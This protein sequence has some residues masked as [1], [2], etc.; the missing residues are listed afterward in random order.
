M[1]KKVLVLPGDN[2]GPE[3]V[4]EAV[5]VLERVSEQ[6]DLGIELDYAHLGGAALDAVGEPCPKETLDKARASDAILLGAVGGPQWDDVERHLRPEKGLLSIRSELDLFGNLRPAIMY[7][8]LAH[9]SSL[10]PEFVSGLDILIVRELVGGIY[11]GEPRG[12]R[13][14]ENGEREGFNT[15][16][17]NESE[18]RRIGKMAFEAAMVRGKRL[19]SVDKSNVLEATILWREI[20]SDMAADYPEVAL[21]HMYVDNAAMQLVKKPKQFDVMV[22]GNMFGDILSDTAA[23]LTGSIGMLPS[24]S[25]D[26]DGGGM[27]E[28]CHGSAPDIAG[29]GVA[30]PLA[31]ILSVAM[32]LRYSLNAVEAADAIE[33]AVSDVLDQGLRT[34]DIYTDGMTRVGTVEMGDAVVAAL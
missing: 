3:I 19:C 8:Q 27:Y 16:K 25:L 11:F 32:M 31:T 20:I 7:P 21:S 26:K 2:I 4:T 34:G 10:K 1:S 18:I 17:Y 5:K 24:A 28:P 15:Y 14:L 30:N 12:I 29:Q 13:T 9:A 22:T 33:K 23:M 6:F